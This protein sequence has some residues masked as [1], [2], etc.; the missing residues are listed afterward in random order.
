MGKTK[1]RAK[2]PVLI[3]TYGYPGSGKSYFARNLTDHFECAHLQSDRIRREVFKEPTYDKQE[4][5]IVKH[6]MDYM[7][8]EF[9]GAG[10]SVIYDGDVFRKNQRFALRQLA[11]KNQAETMVIWLQ[12]DAESARMRTESRDRRTIDD[13]YAYPHTESSFQKYAK[14]MQHPDQ[15]ENYV[16]VSGKHTFDSQRSAV[17]K[18][19][20]SDGI[21]DTAA[22]QSKLIKPGLV[23]L[24]PKAYGDSGNRSISIR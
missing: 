20:L 10:I 3:M 4:T 7:T 6:L 24:I 5:S 11:R 2:K 19:L 14:Y 15:T 23:N 21:V 22:A 16:V 1:V 9:L 18:K 8:E 17:F 13:K 12:I